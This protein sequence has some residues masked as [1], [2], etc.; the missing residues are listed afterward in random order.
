M[1][2]NG[3]IIRIYFVTLSRSDK[4]NYPCVSFPQR[5]VH[6]MGSFSVWW[7]VIRKK[8]SLR[9]LTWGVL[10]SLKLVVNLIMRR[11]RSNTLFHTMPCSRIVLFFFHTIVQAE[12]YVECVLMNTNATVHLGGTWFIFSFFD[13]MILDTT[14]VLNLC[15]CSNDF[16]WGSASPTSR[17]WLNKLN[18]LPG[19]NL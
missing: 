12:I 1:I 8:G 16:C 14:S 11:Y 19:D 17:F 5:T 9:N 10:A 7:W 18:P 2:Y 3:K 6:Q 13:F 15:N 4:T